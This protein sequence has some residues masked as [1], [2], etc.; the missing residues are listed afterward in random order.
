MLDLDRDHGLRRLFHLARRRVVMGFAVAAIAFTLATPTWTTLVAGT[1]IALAGEA[2]RLWAAGHLVKGRE[3]TASGPYR[4][5]QHPLYV[6]SG[7]LGVGFSVIAAN[8]VVA[9]VVLGYVGVMTA[10]AIRLETA[11][12]RDAFGEDYARYVAGDAASA[13]GARRFSLRRAIDNRE[14][15]AVAGLLGTVAVMAVK[16]WFAAP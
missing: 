6:G 11:T 12:L 8:W 5:M 15:H 2:L 9:V 7:I 13:A 14:H 10:A 1:A 16:A 4:W 3:V